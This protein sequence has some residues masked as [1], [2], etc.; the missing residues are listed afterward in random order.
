MKLGILFSLDT[1][2]FQRTFISVT[3]FKVNFLNLAINFI[4][5][6]MSAIYTNVS[7]ALDCHLRFQFVRFKIHSELIWIF[8]IQNSFRNWFLREIV[9][10]RKRTNPIWIPSC[11]CRLN[12]VKILFWYSMRFGIKAMLLFNDHT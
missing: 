4:R 10:G 3:N 7:A 9:I 1:K 2:T 5:Y 6:N 12:T 11:F 8:I